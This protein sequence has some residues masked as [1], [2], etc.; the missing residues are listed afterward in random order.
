MVTREIEGKRGEIARESFLMTPRPA[1][2]RKC[3]PMCFI[4]RIYIL[5][6][7]NQTVHVYIMRYINKDGKAHRA[8]PVINAR[9]VQRASCRDL[10]GG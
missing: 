2:R 10:A 5:E 4:F 7:E 1:F 6:L 9:D 3:L 8:E